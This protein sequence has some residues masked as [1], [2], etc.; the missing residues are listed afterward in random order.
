MAYD[1]AR[2]GSHTL[3]RTRCKVGLS[4]HMP[5]GF[6]P[7]R[8]MSAKKQPL[9]HREECMDAKRLKFM[10]DVMGTRILELHEA[11]C[12]HYKPFRRCWT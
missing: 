1:M 8:S 5:A 7:A 4:L 2:G 12:S 11:K 10:V 3:S 6:C 9:L